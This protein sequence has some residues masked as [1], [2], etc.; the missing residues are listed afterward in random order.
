VKE[1]TTVAGLNRRKFLTQAGLL[2][3][4]GYAASA[5]IPAAAASS[6]ARP[7]EPVEIDALVI[8]A[9][10]SGSVAALR[11]GQAGVRTIVLERGRWWPITAA[12][13][14]FAEPWTP[15]GRAAW[16]STSYPVPRYAGVVEQVNGNGV[17]VHSGAGVGGGS[18]VNNGV[19]LQ[20]VREQFERSFGRRLNYDEM[21]RVWYP[22]A[23]RLLGAGPIPDDVL[24]SDAYFSARKFQDEAAA[25]GLESFRPDVLLDWNVVRHEL[26]GK[27]HPSASVGLGGWGMNSG[28]KLSVDR[29]IMPAA[30]RSGKVTV[31]TLHQVAEIRR[32]RDRYIVDADRINETGDVLER[33]R[34]KARYVFLAAGSTGTSQIL[35]RAKGRG[36]LPQLNNQVGRLWGPGG[37]LETVR[38]GQPY[39]PTNGGPAHI[40]IKHWDNPDGAVTLGSFP[41]GPSPLGGGIS[42]AVGLVAAPPLGSFA[43]DAGADSVTLNWPSTDPV[44]VRMT[45]AVAGTLE[46]L[47]AANPGTRTYHLNAGGTPLPL[48]GAV[49]GAVTD[50]DGQV[51]GYPN[52]FVIDSALIPGS[53]G[54]VPPSLTVTA[55]ADRCVTTALGRIARIPS[56]AAVGAGTH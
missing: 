25:A 28:A 17:F 54:A 16:M 46:R 26:A 55:L 12:A 13:D 20:P 48:G 4:A 27:A 19:T 49:L 23:R 39:E 34:F 43:Y 53:T 38:V 11:L 30:Q 42:A 45:T 31:R 15:D 18:L 5:G 29:T 52:L 1:K 8:G 14:T 9:G 51:Q 37:E 10:Y 50:C 7:G 22:R 24:A 6:A 40:S 3:A 36:T 21:N 41:S 33:V 44:V 47:N 2:T 56:P 35:M 32:E